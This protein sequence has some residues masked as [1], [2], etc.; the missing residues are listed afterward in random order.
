M[1]WVIFREI[2]FFGLVYSTVSDGND[3]HTWESGFH[4][5]L[6]DRF[7]VN[8]FT[9]NHIICAYGKLSDF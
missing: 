1:K 4:F 7:Q 6:G 2:T 5:A 8:T 9:E 3:Q